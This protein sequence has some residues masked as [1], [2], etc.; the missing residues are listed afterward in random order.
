MDNIK[1]GK[2]IA[3]CRREK[4]L[5]QKQLA[6]ELNLSNKTISKWESG[7]GSPDIS[8]LSEVAKVLGITVDELL[9]GERKTEQEDRVTSENIPVKKKL[10]KAQIITITLTLL[11]AAIGGVWGIIA[12]NNGW[13]G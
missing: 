8:N 7:S 9:N 4:G 12:Y 5:T 13:L 2:L 3:E 10:S 6:D 11:G 1:I